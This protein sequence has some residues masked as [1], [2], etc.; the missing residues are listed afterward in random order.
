MMPSGLLVPSSER[1]LDPSPPNRIGKDAMLCAT[2]TSCG[3]PE[4]ANSV[5]ITRNIPASCACAYSS[6]W[7]G[8]ENPQ[9]VVAAWTRTLQE[10]LPRCLQIRNCKESLL[11][12]RPPRTALSPQV[13]PRLSRLLGSR[14]RVPIQP[15]PP[16]TRTPDSTRA[17]SLCEVGC[18]REHATSLRSCH[19]L[20][21]ALFALFGLDDAVLHPSLIFPNVTRGVGMGTSGDGSNPCKLGT[22][23]S[24]ANMALRYTWS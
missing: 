15:S 19:T 20:C 17:S 18:L 12:P 22:S 5:S 14:P 10:D 7:D 6:D 16:S 8:E 3:L 9:H 13:Y 21:V 2:S 24:F 11:S 4:S 1:F 23:C